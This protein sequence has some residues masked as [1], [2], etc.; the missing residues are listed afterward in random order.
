MKKILTKATAIFS[1]VVMLSATFG[2][3]YSFAEDE[4]TTEVK[5]S[6]NITDDMTVGAKTD[7]ADFDD[8]VTDSAYASIPKGVFTKEGYV[9]SGWTDNG[10]D[11]YLAGDSY[12]F[13]EGITEVVFEPVW[14]DPKDTN[15][16]NIIY[17][18]DYNG[19]TIER[20][21]WLKDAVSVVGRIVTPDY[22]RI[23]LDNAVSHNLILGDD[24]VLTYNKRFV[25]PDTDVVIHHQ[26]VERITFTY[27]A[28]DVDRL[29]GNDTYS[30]PKFG[31]ILT[32]LAGNDRFSRDGFELVGW[33]SDYDGEVY[34]PL[35][36]ITAPPTDVT[37]TAVWSPKTYNVLFR[38]G[39]GG[40]NIKVEGATDTKIICPEPDITVAGKYF[41]GWQDSEGNI[42][43]AGS[44]YTVLGAKPGSGIILTALWNDGEAPVTTTPPITTTTTIVTT[45]I[46]ENNSELLGDANCDGKVTI[47]DATAIIQHLGNYDEYALS[48][49]GKLNADIVDRGDGV[50]GVDANAIQAIEA[51]FL[52]QNDFPITKTDYDALTSK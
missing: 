38:Q 46:T 49:Q 29:N 21:E 23:E 3:L 19:E 25:M 18:L 9:F 4:K 30:F 50:T 6:F 20:P 33:L 51:G 11:G 41:A 26:W 44:E 24:H 47:A 5:V 36:V 13:P 42:Y 27:Y 31:E 40:Q 39:N 16:H 34:K 15:V 28:G 48:E 7:I 32:D 45:T 8:F 17:S 22:T 52:K 14:F 37:F 35:Q 12:T 43:Q 1:S 2:S 10:I